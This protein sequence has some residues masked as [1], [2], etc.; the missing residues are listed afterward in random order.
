M[1]RVGGSKNW[2][3][4]VDVIN[5][6]PLCRAKYRDIALVQCWI[7][8]LRQITEMKQNRFFQEIFYNWLFAILCAKAEW[9]KMEKL[10]LIRFFKVPVGQYSRKESNEDTKRPKLASILPSKKSR[11][12][13]TCNSFKFHKFIIH[14]WCFESQ[15][16]DEEKSATKNNS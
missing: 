15:K 16:D 5:G 12:A 6:W 13:E 1:V 7:K 14:T 8:Y 10:F 3:F 11:H 9:V 2:S 4:F